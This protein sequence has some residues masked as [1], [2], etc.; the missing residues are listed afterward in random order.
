MRVGRRTSPPALWLQVTGFLLAALIA[1]SVPGSASDHLDA[2]FSPHVHH[3]VTGH[4]HALHDDRG[5]PI[6][7][8]LGDHGSDGPSLRSD[9]PAAPSL[10]TGER[11][12]TA[13]F[14]IAGLV[15][16]A[17]RPLLPEIFRPPAWLTEPSLPPPRS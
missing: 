16:L 13:G 3:P 4:V 2:L 10:F 1:L 9:A 6:E 5:H 7:Y 15:L 11:S 8:Q 12:L 14:L 17:L